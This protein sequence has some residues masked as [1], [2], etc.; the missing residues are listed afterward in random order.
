MLRKPRIS[1]RA[2]DARSSRRVMA[3]L[4]NGHFAAKRPS[5]TTAQIETASRIQPGLVTGV[6]ALSLFSSGATSVGMAI[7]WMLDI[8]VSQPEALFYQE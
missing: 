3:S 8:R 2:E 5:N 7:D 6:F 1:T 4:V